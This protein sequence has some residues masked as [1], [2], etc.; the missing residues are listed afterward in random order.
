[1][2]KAITKRFMEMTIRALYKKLG[3]LRV[4]DIPYKEFKTDILLICEFAEYRNYEYK[5]RN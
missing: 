3:G 5:K 4:L 2:K 1:M